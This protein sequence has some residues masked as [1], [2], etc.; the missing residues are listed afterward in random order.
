M[1]GKQDFVLGSDLGSDVNVTLLR[2]CAADHSVWHGFTMGFKYGENN[3]S[4]G[5]GVCYQPTSQ[6]PNK[7]N[8]EV[9]PCFN[10]AVSLFPIPLR[11][12]VHLIDVILPGS[13]FLTVE[14]CTEF[15]SNSP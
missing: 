13:F 4:N 5:F 6:E 11:G 14:S 8:L 2:V 15:R 1:T 3:E 7:A 10:I 9:S 12:I